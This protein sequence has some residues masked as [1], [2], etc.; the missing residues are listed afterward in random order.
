MV[1]LS[2]MSFHQ[3][4]DGRKGTPSVMD[5]HRLSALFFV[6]LMLISGCLSG[7]EP[8]PIIEDDAIETYEIKA[9]WALAPNTIIMGEEATLLV[10]VEQIGVGEYD[11]TPSVLTPTFSSLQELTWVKQTD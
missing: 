1:V 7:A 11:V 4:I 6:S 5:K 3:H 9:S 2:R 10:N 8:E